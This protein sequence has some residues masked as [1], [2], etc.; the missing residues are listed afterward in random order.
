LV[1]E[2]IRITI[3]RFRL[4][5]LSL[6]ALPTL[7]VYGPKRS[8]TQARRLLQMQDRI[9]KCFAEVEWVFAM[10]SRA[11]ISTDPAPFSMG[12]TT[13]ILKA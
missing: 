9:L 3:A 11:E 5:I 12:E 1:F 7:A 2:H 10:T 6:L 8:A 13:V 4:E